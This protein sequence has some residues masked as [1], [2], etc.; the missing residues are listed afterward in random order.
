MIEHADNPAARPALRPDYS[1]EQLRQW[2]QRHQANVARARQGG[3]DVAFFG[4]S[5]TQGWLDQG[6]PAWEAF[7][8]PLRAAAFGIPGDRTQ[9]LLWR[10]QHGELEGCSPCVVVL[11]IGTNNLDPGLGGP[12]SLTRQN[13]IAEIIAGVSAIVRLVHGRFP[14][15]RVLLNGLLPRGDADAPVRCEIAAINAGLQQMDDDG[16]SVL[17]I[18]AGAALLEP[19]GSPGAGLMADHLHLTEHG[20]RL[21]APLLH[22][23]LLRL[24]HG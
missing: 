8:A 1:P 5:L 24:L 13:S 11:L 18:D 16:R 3:I 21:W 12:P 23:P 19:D 17:F 4:D 14:H 9:Q 7:F 6:R 15:T 22:A 10:M 20:Y 2:L